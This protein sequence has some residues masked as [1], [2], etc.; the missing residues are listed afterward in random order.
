VCP[1]AGVVLVAVIVSA[2]VI[3]CLF[4]KRMTGIYNRQTSAEARIRADTLY[5]RA[6]DPNLPAEQ[7]ERFFNEAA[8]N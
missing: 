3:G 8:E 7:I 5:E 1:I 6:R 4:R 2:I